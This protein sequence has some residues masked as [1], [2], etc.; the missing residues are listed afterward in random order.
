MKEKLIKWLKLSSSGSPTVWMLFASTRSF[1]DA[2]SHRQVGSGF[3]LS[4]CSKPAKPSSSSSVLTRENA[5]E[6]VV[7]VDHH[8]EEV[9]DVV[10]AVLSTRRGSG[11]RKNH[12]GNVA[13]V[14]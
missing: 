4:S 12:K 3:A 13:T 11:V 2:K 7:G 6:A 5:Q 8:V 14:S 10:D 9:V 1:F